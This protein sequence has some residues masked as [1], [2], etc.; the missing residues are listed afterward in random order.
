MES[1]AAKKAPLADELASPL[2]EDQI[3]QKASPF[4]DKTAQE[5][6]QLFLSK[7]FDL[8][9]VD[10]MRGKGNYINPKNGRQYHIDPKD[11]GRYQEPNHV[12]VSRP[13]NY[14]GSL[15]T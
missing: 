8:R 1:T 13:K 14:T 6:D 2:I 9:G 5:L 10:C 3:W 15:E 4:R 11:V 12:D 7:G